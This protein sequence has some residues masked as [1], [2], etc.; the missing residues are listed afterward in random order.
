MADTEVGRSSLEKLTHQVVTALPLGSFVTEFELDPENK[1]L[2]VFRRQV[3]WS[4]L[5]PWFS[6]NVFP[7]TLTLHDTI[8]PCAASSQDTPHSAFSLGNAIRI[9]L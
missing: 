9:Q 5:V 6:V 7:F 2:K 4:D 1:I 8:V 3:M